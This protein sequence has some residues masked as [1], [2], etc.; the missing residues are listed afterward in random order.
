MPLAVSG[1]ASQHHHRGGH[2]VGRQPLGQ[3]GA[4]G[5]RVGG[6][7][8]VA[9][10]A[11]V[12]GAVFAGDDGGVVDAVECGQ[13][14]LDFAEFDAVAA[15]LD[16]FVG[17]P[18]VVQLPVGAP[19]HQIPGAIHPRPGLPERAGHKPCR[20]QPGP[21]EIADADAAAGHIQLTDHSG[22]HRAQ[23]VVQDEQ[24]RAG[25]R[26]TDRHRPRPRGQWRADRGVD[27]G[28]GG[29]VGVDHH[30]PG[31]P[32]VHHLGRAGLAADQQR[33][34]LQA[35]AVRAPRPRRGFG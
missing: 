33:H 19:A 25:H 26:R 28:F 11:F 10:E 3:C 29:A 31:R 5:G 1:S 35:L 2:H 30:P 23:P 24:R 14:G 34:R 6:S 7:G 32:P 17:A 13:G 18:E 8:D 27:G 21:A 20:G 16:L 4:R 12:A 22:R 15:D 9:D